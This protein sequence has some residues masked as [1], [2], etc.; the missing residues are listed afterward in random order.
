MRRYREL[1]AWQVAFDLARRVYFWT[2]KL[3]QGEVCGLQS[4]MRRAAVLIASNSAEGAGRATAKEFAQF[5]VIARASLNELETQVLLAVDPGLHDVDST[6]QETI[7]RL[8]GLLNGL[9]RALVASG[10]QRKTPNLGP[11]DG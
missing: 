2:E 8:F 10:A 11:Q 3:P 4:Q 1:V 5:V 6:L 9:R 7:E